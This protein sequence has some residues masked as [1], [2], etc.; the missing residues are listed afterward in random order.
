MHVPR[1]AVAL[2]LGASAATV[3]TELAIYELTDNGLPA[4]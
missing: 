1:L 2:A 3:A 4:S